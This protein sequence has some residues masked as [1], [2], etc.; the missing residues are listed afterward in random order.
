MRSPSAP[1]A[2][3]C[4]KL[5]TKGKCNNEKEITAKKTAYQLDCGLILAG[6]SEDGEEQC[7]VNAALSK[8]AL[9]PFAHVPS[10][11]QTIAAIKCH[12][13]ENISYIFGINIS[14]RGI[15]CCIAG[16]GGHWN[17]STA[18]PA[19]SCL[20]EISVGRVTS[21]ICGLQVPVLQVRITA[22]QGERPCTACSLAYLG[23]FP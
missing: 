11:S 21:P 17:S 14:R 13:N 7:R 20:R 6:R 4:C 22:F 15:C 8:V 5:L 1:V 16:V 12:K 19:K 3:F 9:A 2:N 23:P 18:E 10:M